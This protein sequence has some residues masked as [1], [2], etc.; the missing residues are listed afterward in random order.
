MIERTQP[1]S[2]G[3]LRLGGVRQHARGHSRAPAA[4]GTCGA[5]G[6]FGT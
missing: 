5:Y 3:P 1:F 2:P 4:P 6:G